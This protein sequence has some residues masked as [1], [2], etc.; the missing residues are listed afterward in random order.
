MSFNKDYY[1]ERKNKIMAI[2]QK[3]TNNFLALVFDFVDDQR[4]LA[5]QKRD[6][7]DREK[8]SLKKDKK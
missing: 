4:E 1:E 3:K 8:E 6:L 7:E 2:G 5:M